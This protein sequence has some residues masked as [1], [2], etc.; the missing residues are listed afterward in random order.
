MAIKKPKSKEKLIDR[1]KPK[2]Q[3][4]WTR[5]ILVILII[6]FIVILFIPSNKMFG[7]TIINA[8]GADDIITEV[9]ETNANYIEMSNENNQIKIYKAGIYVIS[10]ECEDGY[11]YIEAKKQIVK[12]ILDNLQLSSSKSSCIIID[13]A[14]KVFIN[15]K[16]GTV[17]TINTSS[18][19]FIYTNEKG[20]ESTALGAIYSKDDLTING[21]GKLI[22]NSS[23]NGVS[24]NDDLVLYSCDINITSL[25]HGINCN[26]SFSTDKSQIEINSQKD[27]IHSVN[28]DISYNN[29]TTILGGQIQINA[30][31]DGIDSSGNLGITDGEITIK[32]GS[33]DDLI[34]HKGFSSQINVII[35]GGNININTSDKGIKADQDIIINDG[36]IIISGYTCLKAD[37]DIEIYNGKINLTSYADGIN[38]IKNL[39]ISGGETLISASDD[40]LHSD[41][42]VT[43]NSGVINIS[44]SSEGIE[45]PNIYINDGKITVYASDDGI[46]VNCIPNEMM[47]GMGGFFNETSSNTFSSGILIVNGGILF[48]NS[49]GDGLDSNDAI[50]INGGIVIV[51]GPVNSGNGAFDYDTTCKVTGGIVIVSG[52]SGMAQSPSTVTQGTISIGLTTTV[53][54]DS[55][56]IITDEENNLIMGYVCEKQ[57]SHIVLSNPQFKLNSTYNIYLNGEIEG[58]SVNGYYDN[59]CEIKNLGTLYKNCT[60]SSINYSIGTSGNSFGGGQRPGGWK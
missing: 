24:C 21:L 1:I 5:L 32:I 57:Y 13:D 30:E 6:L 27:G 7:H 35:D 25:E 9:P 48:V 45:A 55:T 14:K 36:E 47:G 60:L 41:D 42:T 56:I 58:E 2:N 38:A 52:S 40:G 8:I 16:T 28:N 26:E 15:C 59:T 23:Y 54:Q 3:K 22:I 31:Q 12:I 51:S 10:G 17:N 34:S 18:E 11:I 44:K 49:Y 33:N 20:L 39:T 37:N 46:N 50:E 43:I 19:H 4:E 53:A 29:Y